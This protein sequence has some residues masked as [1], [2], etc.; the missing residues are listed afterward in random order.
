MV[1][2][3]RTSEADGM[4]G[5]SGG[6]GDGG[7]W[8]ANKRIA[9][10]QGVVGDS[11]VIKEAVT[12]LVRYIP[13]LLSPTSPFAP[14]RSANAASS[15]TSPPSFL[16]SFPPCSP[17]SAPSPLSSSSSLIHTRALSSASSPSEP[18]KKVVAATLDGCSDPTTITISN[19]SS[20]SSSSSRSNGSSNAG[21]LATPGPAI[22]AAHPTP[23]APPAGPSPPTS[24]SPASPPSAPTPHRL[25]PEAL[26][27]KQQQ[28]AEARRAILQAEAEAEAAAAASGSAAAALDD[29]PMSSVAVPAFQTDPL[30]PNK[31]SV[32]GVALA[33]GGEAMG[34]MRRRKAAVLVALFE[35]EGGELRVWLTKRAAKLSSHSGEVALPGGKRDEGDADDSDTALREAEEEI[36]LHRSHARVVTHLEP[37]LSKHLLTVTPVVALLPRGFTFVP[38]P[39]AD[40]VQAVF[41]VPLSLFLQSE[42]HR[43]EDHEWLGLPYRVHFFEYTA[44]PPPPHPLPNLSSA[45]HAPLASAT[46]STSQPFVTHTPP[47]PSMAASPAVLTGQG[48][49]A[50]RREL[51]EGAEEEQAGARVGA[52]EG[53]HFT[54][55]GL[56]A[57]ILVRVSCVVFGRS[58]PF[59]E[60][61][62]DAPNYATVL[63]DL[64][65]RQFLQL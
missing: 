43:H 62:P 42:H 64:A 54:I 29:T 15:L 2:P 36:G 9:H 55:W 1:E 8:E 46:T 27:L 47:Q 57:A 34:P 12:R 33:A 58:A 65:K 18:P 3:G 51:Q 37:F 32:L 7:G 26:A 22:L 10:L 14:P 4:F 21:N 53:D 24:P 41:S 25:S 6:S 16:S 56:T 38:R 11:A 19:G 61:H 28:A 31:Q 60:F 39:N 30:S 63:A 52:A 48:S 13:P 5:G 59:G 40:E 20:S 50:V 23:P 44:P 17:A 49:S 35:G 45:P